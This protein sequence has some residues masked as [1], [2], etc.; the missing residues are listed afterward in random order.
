MSRPSRPRRSNSAAT[1]LRRA[2]SSSAANCR[3]MTIVSLGL[4]HG[5]G[6][7]AVVATVELFALTPDPVAV[8]SVLSKAVEADRREVLAGVVLHDPVGQ[9][10]PHRGRACDAQSRAP[11][12][13]EQA[14][15]ARHRADQVSTV[16]SEG[17]QSPPVGDNLSL[18]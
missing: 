4:T 15:Y 5:H 18:L 14:L 13:G 1:D 10:A 11:G 2:A 17:R 3:D 16:G 6:G 7:N 8:G 9:P 12:G